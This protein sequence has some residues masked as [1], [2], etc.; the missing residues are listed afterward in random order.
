M[1]S[2]FHELSLTDNNDHL[3][4]RIQYAHHFHIVLPGANPFQQS[5]SDGGL[6]P[7]LVLY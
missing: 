3:T 7:C 2:V 1:Q 6:V 4:L 5:C